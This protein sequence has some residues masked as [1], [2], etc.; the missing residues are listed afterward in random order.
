MKIIRSLLSLIV[1]YLIF[2]VSML[3]LWMVFGYKP[4]DVPPDGFLVFSIFCECLFALG[5][6]YVAA[7]ISNRKELVHTGILAGVVAIMGVLSLFW[8][9]NELSWWANL[10]TAFPI[11]PCFP[12]GGLIRKKSK[13]DR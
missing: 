5:G 6:G 11:A 7:F 2:V 3:I 12:L 4:K 1:G 13:K 10:A 8:P 9:H